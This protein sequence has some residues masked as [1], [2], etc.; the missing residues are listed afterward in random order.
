[1]TLAALFALAG[2]VLWASDWKYSYF[3]AM[4]KFRSGDYKAA[5]RYLESALQEKGEDCIDCLREEGM[6]YTDYLPHYYLGLAYASLK[7]P[8]KALENLEKLEKSG[9]LSRGRGLGPASRLQFDLALSNA[10]LSRERSAARAGGDKASETRYLNCIREPVVI[11]RFY[12]ITVRMCFDP[13][14]APSIEAEYDRSA[15]VLDVETLTVNQGRMPERAVK[16][17]KEW[18]TIRRD[19]LSSAWEDLGHGKRPSVIPLD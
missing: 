4:D 12:G 7:Q 3:K 13:S 6:F 16:I 11:S 9:L 5:A 14:A 8:E 15:V 18:A 19:D 17:L 1:V 10:R 2:A